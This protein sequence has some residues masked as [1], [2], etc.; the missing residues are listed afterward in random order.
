[1]FFVFVLHHYAVCLMG[2]MF[3]SMTGSNVVVRPLPLATLWRLYDSLG[4]GLP[5][6]AET[7]R[8]VYQR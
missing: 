2:L 7:Y 4:Y 1:M 5:A 6:P 3:E 8:S